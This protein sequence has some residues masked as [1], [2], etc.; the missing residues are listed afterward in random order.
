[1]T[2]GRSE[3]S[4][5][6]IYGFSAYLV[7]GLFP[8]YWPLLK[9][10]GAVE[11]LVHRMLWS[12]IFLAIVAGIRRNW[13]DVWKVLRTPRLAGLL[14]IAAVLITIN[15]GLYI[16]AINADH[17]I[18]ASLGY[19][20]NPLINVAFGVLAFSERL[21]RVQ[22]VAVSIAAAGVLWLTVDGG[23]LPWIG[24]TLGITFS[25]Y[26]AVKKVADVESTESLTIETLLLLPFSLGYLVWSEQ[27]G[28]AAFGHNGLWHTVFTMM[29][30]VITALPL[31]AFGAA[32][33]RI[34]YSLMGLMQYIT[35]SM[36]F[37]L[38]LVV[39][40]EAMS[41]ARWAGFALIWVALAIF[42]TDAWRRRL[43]V[44]PL[45]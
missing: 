23:Q 44:E 25:A 30:G 22:W 28:Q 16:W 3:H 40:H 14:T 39:F 26:G 45:D 11:I 41:G 9:P 38:G 27:A 21:R 43:K 2:S 12:F 1:M 6:V 8:L 34:P 10:A 32:A 13:S 4:K 31:I 15:W 35:P 17:V 36:Q 5:G 19:F 29:A 24:L 20:I 42:G 18:D 33:I 37:L 7:W